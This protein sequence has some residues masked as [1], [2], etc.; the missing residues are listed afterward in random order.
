VGSSGKVE[1]YRVLSKDRMFRGEEYTILQDDRR[2]V[3]DM[4][5]LVGLVIVDPVDVQ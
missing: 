4:D 3:V 1:E 5:L 2:E